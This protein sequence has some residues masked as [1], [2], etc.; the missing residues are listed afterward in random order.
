M[1]IVMDTV[2]VCIGRVVVWKA[3][4]SKS[5]IVDIQIVT[6]LSVISHASKGRWCCC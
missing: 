4:A 6:G 2:A 1:V 5:G 3:T